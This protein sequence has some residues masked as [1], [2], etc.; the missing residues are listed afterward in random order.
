M[1]GQSPV[2][3]TD[4]EVLFEL[5]REWTPPGFTV[6]FESSEK[7]D[8]IL[9]E[10]RSGGANRRVGIKFYGTR[11]YRFRTEGN[12]TEWHTRDVYDALAEILPSEWVTELRNVAA[13]RD[14][15][16]FTI[17]HYL[18]YVEDTGA[19][20]IAAASWAVVELETSVT[21]PQ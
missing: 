21:D 8:W 19:Y 3:S 6:S 9:F 2:D 7:G 1:K 18:L 4:R 17:H 12:C 13:A 10:H 15:D 16:H 5:P 20:E 11:A 14:T